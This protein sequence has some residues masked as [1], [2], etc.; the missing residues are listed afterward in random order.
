MS[1]AAEN[2]A[3]VQRPEPLWTVADVRAFLRI[4]RN[5]V[6]D[7]ATRGELPSIRI[8][9]RVRFDPAKVRAWLD[10]QAGA[11]GKVLPFTAGGR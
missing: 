3:S 11:G 10:S 7:L 6:Y 4:G 2:S 1:M 9:S 5:T 8:G